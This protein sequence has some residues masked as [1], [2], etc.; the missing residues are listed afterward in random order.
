M[1]KVTVVMECRR[2]AWQLLS[3][4]EIAERNIC[5]SSRDRSDHW[6]KLQANARLRCK[7]WTSKEFSSCSSSTYCMVSL[8]TRESSTYKSDMQPIPAKRTKARVRFSDDAH[9][10]VLSSHRNRLHKFPPPSPAPAHL[11][12]R[13]PAYRPVLHALELFIL[14]L[15]VAISVLMAV[16]AYSLAWEAYV[17]SFGH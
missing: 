9:R 16:W 15:S 6:Q 11:R 7:S 4:N 13:K 12:R 5:T 17:S 14:C 1:T 8:A 3:D 2:E 10:I